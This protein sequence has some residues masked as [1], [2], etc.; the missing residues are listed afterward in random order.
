MDLRKYFKKLEELEAAM[1]EPYQFVV[2]L[3]TSDGGKAGMIAKVSRANAAKLIAEN[4][5]VLA[6]EEQ[7]EQL[8]AQ[9]KAARE[10]VEQSETARRV[11]VAI[12]TEADLA[13]LPGRRNS[14]QQSK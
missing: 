1:I 12:L 3:E 8:A 10:A 14:S 4:R 6:T 11:Q 7:K 9:Q 13:K 5:A 2:S